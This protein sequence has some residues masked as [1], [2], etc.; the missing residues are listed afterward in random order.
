M[1]NV[2]LWHERDLTHSSVERIII[3][4]SCIL[5]DYIL[6]RFKTVMENLVIYPDHMRAN[7]DKTWG[8]IFSQRVMLGLVERGMTREEAYRLVQKNSMQAWNQGI[9]LQDLVARDA[10]IT[11]YLDDR[12]AGYF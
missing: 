4:D 10:E 9:A 8:L 3:P 6:D 5:L 7:L 2:A 11:K 1:E 12:L